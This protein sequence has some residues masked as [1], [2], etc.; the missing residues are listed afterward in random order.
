MDPRPQTVPLLLRVATA[1]CMAALLA[2]CQS[3]D[4]GSAQVRVIDASVDAGSIDAYQNS[5]GIA[6][7]LGA[8]TLTSYVATPPGSYTLGAEKS[9]TRIALAESAARLTAGRDYTVLLGGTLANLQQTTP[10]PAGEVELRFVQ[11]AMRSGPVDVYLVASRGRLAAT[12]PIATGMNFGANSGYLAVP[13]GTYAIDVVPAGTTLTNTT[14]TLLSGPQVEYDSG[15][16]RTVVLMDQESAG[17]H[18]AGVA[19]VVADDADGN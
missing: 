4:M 13:A 17:S 10:A 9:G 7:N 8:G 3:I 11:Q 18:G 2:G 15:A 16:V 12:S 6:Y 1:M 14:V 19:V 5:T